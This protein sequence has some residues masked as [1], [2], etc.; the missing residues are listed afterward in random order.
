MKMNVIICLDDKSGMTFNNRRQSRD[1]TLTA[2]IINLCKEKKLLINNFSKNLFEDF[3]HSNITVSEDFLLE[4]SPGD[5][6]FVENKELTPFEQFIEKIIVFKWNRSYPCDF[7]LDI[8][9]DEWNLSKTVDF[10][11]NSH[12][13][14]TMEV[15]NK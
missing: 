2:K 13:K 15:Y 6:C 11:G 14:I 1:K 7:Y 3:E 12:E 9:L 4:A 8:P 5:F 10:K